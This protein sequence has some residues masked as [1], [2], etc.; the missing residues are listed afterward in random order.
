MVGSVNYALDRGRRR[1]VDSR[2]A[3]LLARTPISEMAR[4][5]QVHREDRSKEP[6][7]RLRRP[8]NFPRQIAA[9][10]SLFRKKGAG[11]W[12]V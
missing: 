4:D 6:V 2:P 5:R 7:N 3:P 11:E 9:N 1:L 8:D 10:Q 12:A